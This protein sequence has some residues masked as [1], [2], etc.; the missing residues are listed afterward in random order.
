[1]GICALV[2]TLLGGY[3]VS[4]V[5]LRL[6]YDNRDETPGLTMNDI[7]GAYHGV[8]TPSPLIIALASNHPATLGETERVALIAWLKGNRISMDYDNLDLGDMAP[9]EIDR[10]SVV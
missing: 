8:Q 1:M 3:I 5:H 4:G 7:V 9:S 2:I 6:H 10:K